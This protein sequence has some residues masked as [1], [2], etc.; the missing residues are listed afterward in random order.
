MKNLRRTLQDIWQQGIISAEKSI[1]ELEQRGFKIGCLHRAR[2]NFRR[3]NLLT[4]F[5]R[6]IGLIPPKSKIYAPLRDWLEQIGVLRD[7]Q[8]MEK[9]L[10]S[11]HFSWSDGK[12]SSKERAK[13]RKLLNQKIV[14][15]RKKLNQKK[16]LKNLKSALLEFNEAILRFNEVTEQKF[17]K[18]AS[19]ICSDQ[20]AEFMEK[21][22]RSLENGFSIS[23]MHDGRRLGRILEY[24]LELLSHLDTD[25]DIDSKRIH[26]IQRK[27]GKIHDDWCLFLFMKKMTLVTN[28]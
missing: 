10:K 16:R 8:V 13:G 19:R 24:Y 15:S 3:L 14:K 18:R 23:L 21:L 5:Y 9:N 26:V 7:L 1:L 28:L 12:I 20:Y 4:D 11:D 6:H 25:T 17:K 27:L 22:E 2:V